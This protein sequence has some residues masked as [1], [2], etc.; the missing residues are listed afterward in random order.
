MPPER[1]AAARSSTKRK[2]QT[3]QALNA[4][5]AELE[6]AA[7]NARLAAGLLTFPAGSSH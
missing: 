1:P 7:L 2:E 5:K 3:Q 4:R 6:N